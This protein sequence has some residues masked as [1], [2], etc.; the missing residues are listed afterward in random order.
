MNDG[1]IQKPA[2]IGG[3]AL[4]IISALPVIGYCNCVC[5]V[6]AIGAG[7]MS[8][9]L[10]V[11]ESPFLVTMGR[12]ALTGLATGAIGAVVCS[13]FS[14]PLQYILSGGGN[15]AMVVE[16]VRELMA[17]NPDLPLEVHQS[18]EAFLLRG[19]FMMLIAIFSFF[20]NVVFFSLF[21]SHI[22]QQA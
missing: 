17:K 8:A 10:Y 21:A 7:I 9:Y 3:V 22:N 14:I 19:D 13:L 15:S 6:W 18:I 16:Q 20:T 11:K 1:N 2:L 12:G 4:G 5:C